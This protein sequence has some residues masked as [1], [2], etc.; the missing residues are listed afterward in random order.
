MQAEPES[1]LEALFSLDWCPRK[2]PKMS[3]RSGCT[4]WGGRTLPISFCRR[5]SARGLVH[6]KELLGQ[7][8]LLK[9]GRGT[10]MLG[11]L[12]R[13]TFECFA[14]NASGARRPGE[15]QRHEDGSPP[16]QNLAWPGFGLQQTSPR[17]SNPKLEM[18]RDARAYDY[19]QGDEVMRLAYVAVTRAKLHR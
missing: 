7:Q 12:S 17:G 10:S 3:A 13:L 5:G 15:G 16:G 14:E 2:Y 19:A 4:D 1:K 18:N 8:P 11:H 6:E 9:Q